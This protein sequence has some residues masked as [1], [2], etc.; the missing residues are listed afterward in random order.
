ML[1]ISNGHEPHSTDPE[2]NLFIEFPRNCS[3]KE[4]SNL[5]SIFNQ[6]VSI[7]IR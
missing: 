7:N 3:G 4:Y 5:E 6:M 2:L 1:V